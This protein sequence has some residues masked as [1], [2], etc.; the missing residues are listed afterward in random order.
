MKLKNVEKMLNYISSTKTTPE[1]LASLEL[2]AED[3][4]E[5]I[6]HIGRKLSFM[7]VIRGSM[8]DTAPN[9]AVI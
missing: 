9:Y 2:N 4:D 1:L 3:L 6:N 7:K 5:L 8:T